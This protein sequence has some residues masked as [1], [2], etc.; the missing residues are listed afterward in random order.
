MKIKL[1]LALLS[2]FGLYLSAA[3][4]YRVN[5][6]ANTSV[7]KCDSFHCVREQLQSAKASQELDV[8]GSYNITDAA[9][10]SSAFV[11]SWIGQFLFDRKDFVRARKWFLDASMKFQVAKDV[12]RALV[13]SAI[14]GGYLRVGFDAR[15]TLTKSVLSEDDCSHNCRL[16]KQFWDNNMVNF[17]SEYEVLS[18]RALQIQRNSYHQSNVSCLD[19]MKLSYLEHATMKAIFQAAKAK[20]QEYVRKS[21]KQRALKLSKMRLRPTFG[22]RSQSTI[23]VAYMSGDFKNHALGL[24]VCDMFAFHDSSSFNITCYSTNKMDMQ[25][26]IS[27]RVRN[28][29]KQLRVVTGTAW[30]IAKLIHEDNIDILIDLSHYTAGHRHDVLALRPAPIQ[31]TYL[32]LAATTGSPFVDFY[33]V[34]H[35]VV[36]SARK[37]EKAVVVEQKHKQERRWF[38]EAL[39]FMPHSYHVLNHRNL[40]GPVVPV[41]PSLLDWIEIPR[42]RFLFC[43]LGRNVKSAPKLFD[44]W[45]EIIKNCSNSV[46]VLKDH[47]RQSVKW[48]TMEAVARGLVVSPDSQS[49]QVLFLRAFDLENHLRVKSLCDVYLDTHPMN[50]HSTTA[51]ML[52][53]GVPIISLPGKTMASRVSASFAQALGLHKEMVVENYSDYHKLA[54]E[55]FQS[56]KKLLDLK[57]HLQQAVTTSSLF[58]TRQWV[59]DFEKALRS[60]WH[61]YLHQVPFQDIVVS[62]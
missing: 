52:F 19:P 1:I 50:G 54:I 37:Q 10:S 13:N 51:D 42:E 28:S 44:V 24:Q 40:Y 17:W 22:N 32:G 4:F 47:G 12:N 61:R 6:S 14:C 53:A 46:L 9:S 29:C 39:V 43:S 36:A 11:S 55:L 20:A 16:S 26:I 56:P 35:I 58:D 7:F 62:E 38:S 23:N 30:S 60:M 48:W 15:S 45:A 27:Q 57:A 33:I 31:I 41:P 25:D 18:S 3:L 5:A 8:F 21:S 49:S 34:D 2:V 59:R